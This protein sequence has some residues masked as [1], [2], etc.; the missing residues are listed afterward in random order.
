MPKRPAPGADL[1]SAALLGAA[2]PEAADADG[3][4]LAPTPPRP[5]PAGKGAEAGQ[6]GEV[7]GTQVSRPP[8]TLVSRQA[9]IGVHRA[10]EAAQEGGPRVGGQGP[11]V[12]PGVEQ[13][14]ADPAPQGQIGQV[15][16]RGSPLRH[17]SLS[18]APLM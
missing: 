18:S 3:S 8:P 15:A 9:P 13:V 10:L 11:R 17:P 14:G 2:E 5:S 6:A 12:V 7:R 4:G 16:A 1:R